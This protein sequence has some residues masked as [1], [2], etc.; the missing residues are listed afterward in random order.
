[1]TKQ[2]DRLSFRRRL[3]VDPRELLRNAAA[4]GLSDP[5]LLDECRRLLLPLE[6]ADAEH[7]SKLRETLL[8]YYAGGCSMSRA[9][10][11]LFL[12]RNSV[13]YRLDR[14]RALLGLDID[15]PDTSAAF[16]MAC[17]LV[18]AADKSDEAQRA[19]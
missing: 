18:E 12:H 2:P 3:R 15:H 9:A 5:L 8:A 7:G 4:A 10:E 6:R 17:S 1:M 14:V 13:R 11:A 16:L 19:Q